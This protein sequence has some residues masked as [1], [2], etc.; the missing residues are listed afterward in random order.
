TRR[1]SC[2][3]LCPGVS[4]VRPV[5]SASSSARRR[6]WAFRSATVALRA[7]GRAGGGPPC[8]GRR[9]AGSARCLTSTNAHPCRIAGERGAGRCPAS[10]H[11]PL[12]PGRGAGRAARARREWMVVVA[13]PAGTHARAARAGADPRAG[14]GDPDPAQRCAPASRATGGGGLRHP[15]D[16]RGRAVAGW[17]AL[18]PPAR[19]R[20]VGDPGPLPTTRRLAPARGRGD[21]AGTAHAAQPQPPAGRRRSP[22]AEALALSRSAG[23]AD[24]PGPCDLHRG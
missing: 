17:P 2:A 9:F 6:A 22:R 14:W 1:S 5:L 18:V 13:L 8:G 21:L 15:S 11:P 12:R 10:F 19:S 16:G 3:V 24:A 4:P 23:D 7:I 20:A